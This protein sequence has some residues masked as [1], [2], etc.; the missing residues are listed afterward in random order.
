MLTSAAHRTARNL[1]IF[2]AFSAL[3]L[4]FRDARAQQVDPTDLPDP[5]SILR[6]GEDPGAGMEPRTPEQI[7]ALAMQHNPELRA[8]LLAW[9]QT[10]LEVVSQDN[11]FVPSAFGELGYTTGRRPYELP[12]GRQ[13]LSN[14]SLRAAA[15]INHTFRT[16]TQVAAS[17]EVEHAVEDTIFPGDLGDS[18]GLG[19]VFQ[20]SQPWLRGF[21]RD[22]ILA[23]LHL[24]E[25][26]RDSALAERERLATQLARQALD[27]YWALWFAEQ[28]IRINQSALALANQEMARAREQLDVGIIAESDLVPLMTELARL[29]ED[30]EQSRAARR[31]TQF[32]L[33]SLLG[34]SPAQAGITPTA[35]PPEISDHFNEANLQATAQ[36]RSYQLQTL[37]QNIEIARIQ[38]T[39]ARNRSLPDLR[40]NATFRIS[41]L[42]NKVSDAFEQIGGFEA[43][44]AMINLRL[45]LPLINRAA[46][47]DAERAEIG[48]EIARARHQA[49][50]DQLQSRIASA[51]SNFQ[52]ARRR[53]E[54][55]QKT[56][57]LAARQVEIQTTL[58][59]NGTTTML[60]VVNAL[61]QQNQ[62]QLR[63]ARARIDILRL[64]LELED[65][66]GT[67]LERLSVRLGSEAS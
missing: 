62:A 4:S 63:V 43:I 29:E 12:G 46:Q 53:L 28:Q 57:E 45:E 65:A 20:V 3:L 58:F 49:A 47:A 39:L 15:G 37:T 2:G 32:Q 60:D 50:L 11:Q 40:T 9:Q 5:A 36:A 48:V 24:A 10:K 17:I 22:V 51:L 26:R 44:S 31:E 38:A 61:Q 14:D 13:L 19:L 1:V 27:T 16:A 41:G 21:D 59:A 64:R 56:A 66:S 33:A 8:S 7:I 35:Q 6:A 54:L 67:L 18:F 23:E 52:A 34:L 55:S 25:L 30:L 42:G